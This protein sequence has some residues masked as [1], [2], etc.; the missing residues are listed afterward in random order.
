[1]P[2]PAPPL[3]A[4][5]LYLLRFSGELGTKAR[6]TRAQF[7]NRL[8]RNLRDALAGAGLPSRVERRYERLLVESS[9]PAEEVLARVFGLQSLSRVEPRPGE[10]LAEVVEAGH[11]LFAELV[12][13]RRFAVR[14]RRVG[15]R[16]PDFGARDVER[17]LGRALLADAAGVDLEHPELTVYVEL[18]EGRAFF[19]AERLPGPGGLPLGSSG[20]AVALVSGGFDSAVAAWQMQR[21]GLALDYV[22]CNL[23]GA[24]HRLGC[25]RVTKL[26]VER[27]SAGSRPQ[28]VSL[29]FE[30]LAQ[31]LRERSQARLWQVL[32]KRLMLR[33]AEAVAR[34][35]RAGAIVTGEA[36]GQVSS[37]TLPNLAVI[38]QAAGLPI[39]R[40]LLGANKDEIIELARRIGT[41]ELSAV[42]QEYCAMVPR[43][44]A[45]AADLESVLAAEAGL[46]PALLERALAT[47]EVFD[48]HT[49]DPEAQ[50][51][52][53]LEV[54]ELPPDAVVLDLRSRAAWRAWHAPGALQLD[55]ARALAAVP[56]LERGRTYV[57]YC[58]FGL[59]SAHLAERMRA[60]GLRA[61][62]VRG[63][64]RRLLA[65]AGAREELALA[66]PV[67]A[68]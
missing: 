56:S 30:P 64:V 2:A 26:L 46:D 42:V 65:A 1:M 6:A 52:A 15:D 62:H 59:K 36:L 32:L 3:Q 55:L 24:A 67:T 16:R 20:R 34:E 51:P 23:G 61:F 49:L 53:D 54:T 13:G 38:S 10:K 39:L 44:P 48:L 9:A 21:R 19:F 45:T 50:G 27:W 57:A 14:A 29:D 12:R 31:A 66:A 28:L 18:Y 7:V 43:R 47:R 35:R 17:E 68:D 33:A 4:H 58:E 40:P 5:C 11:A 8:V 22:F 25:L 60:A 63:G 41:A 37:Q